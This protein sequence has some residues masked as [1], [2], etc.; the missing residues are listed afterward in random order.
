MPLREMTNLV[1]D[2]IVP[3]LEKVD[4]VG[5]V[6]TYGEAT[7]EI[8]INLDKD[9]LAAYGITTTDVLNNLENQNMDVPAGSLTSGSNEVTVRTAGTITAVDQ[10]RDLPVA[11]QNGVQLYVR[12]IASVE[13]GIKEQDSLAL[14][15]G[16]PAIVI[17][18]IKQ[19][20][21][22][23]TTVADRGQTGPGCPEAATAARRQHRHGA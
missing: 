3:R 13:D 14:F 15:D 18:L 20:G 8:Q 6:N 7:R 19:S 1:D 12:D 4:G 11:R 5:Q 23:T 22:N 21:S 2:M 17:D 10:F 16:K 9:K